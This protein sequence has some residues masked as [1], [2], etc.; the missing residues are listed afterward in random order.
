[1]YMLLIV[2]PP[3][4]VEDFEAHGK[5]E[6]FMGTGPA[7]RARSGNLDGAVALNPFA[8]QLQAGYVR[9]LI[10]L[11]RAA[12]DSGVVTQLLTFADPPIVTVTEPLRRSP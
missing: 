11:Q 12:D 3:P 8:F 9:A 5:L 2:R 10:E 6:R 7:A 1:M 4:G